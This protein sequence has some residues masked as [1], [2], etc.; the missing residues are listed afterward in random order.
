MRQ[1]VSGLQDAGIIATAKHYI[2]YEQEHFRQPGSISEY[3]D[4]PAYTSNLDDRTMHE[5][6][7]WPFSDAVRAGVGAIM[8]SYNQVNNSYA[9]QNSKILNGLLK[10]E[11]GF[12]GFVM[13][14]WGAQLTGT[15]SA[16]AG[17]DM[18]M[19]GDAV[20]SYGELSYW[21]P[22]LTTAVLNG[23]VPLSR[24]DDMAT[25]IMAAY[26]LVGQDQGFP[27]VSFSS[28]TTATEGYLYY[29][30]NEGYGVINQHIDVRGAHGDA[31]IGLA[32]D[33][34]VL[35]KNVNNTLPLNS[36]KQIGV[37]GSDAA[38]GIGGPNQFPD[39][40]GT[41]GTLAMGWGSGTAQFPYLVS[42]LEALQTQA[43][44][45]GSVIQWVVDDFN[46]PLIASTA[47]QATV[48][49]AFVKADSGEGYITVDGNIGDRNN[50][51]AWEEGDKL[52]ATVT[53][54]CAN[55]IVVVHSVGQIN[56]E[57]WVEN[58]NVTAILWA[59]LPGQESGNSL[60]EVIYGNVNPSGRLPFTIAKND[61]DYSSEVLYTPNNG[62]FSAPYDDYSE[63]L[64][65][66][67]R[68]FDARNIT[69]RYEFGFGL[70]YTIFNVPPHCLK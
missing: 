13:S 4:L 69:P 27:D 55:T 37:F 47:Q 2:L 17:L 38:P 70:S 34:V 23:S 31:Q 14:D 41:N 7:L 35:L 61:S 60:V 44:Q 28:W 25:R 15:A 11:L 54:N 67:Y 8:C 56:V 52:I 39:R 51:T 29:G 58:P 16:L 68:A 42:P 1:T 20:L 10:D 19:A 53:G 9:C 59:S 33:S 22:N 49:F 62:D 48:C 26:Y 66:D 21:G 12:Q 24:V 64:L 63:G 46:Y 32:A 36:P 18:T 3:P 40:G 6:Y 45:D 43:R 50:L 65:V 30:A 5:L 57:A